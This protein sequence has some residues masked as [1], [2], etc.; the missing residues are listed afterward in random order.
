MKTSVYDKTTT[1]ARKVSD[2]ELSEGIYR[3]DHEMRQFIR[4]KR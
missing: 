2:K 3:W 1:V 4:V